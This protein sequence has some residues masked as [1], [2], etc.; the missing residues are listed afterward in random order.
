MDHTPNLGLPY[1]MAAQ[2]Q[3]HV[4]HNEAIRALDAILHLAV[5]DRDLTGPPASPADGDRYIVA[6]SATDAWSGH[7]HEIAAFQDGAW[8]FYPPREGW[9]AWLSDDNAAVVWDGTSWLPLA[10]GTG[11]GGPGPNPALL[12][13]NASADISNRLAVSSPASLFS[14]E[15]DGHQLKINKALASATASTLYQNGFSGRAEIGLTGDDDFHFKVSA[16]GDTWHEAIV[17]A[18]GTGAVTFP[19]TVSG[20]GGG[21]QLLTAPRTYHVDISAGSDTNTGL[22]SGAAF[23][24]IQKAIDTVAS[25]DTGIHDVTI[26]IAPGTYTAPNNLKPLSGAGRCYIVG[27]EA[28]PSSVIISLAS[29]TCF[30]ADSVYAIYHLRGMQLQT[31]A[32]GYGIKAA[33]HSKVYYRNMNFGA[34][35]NGHM[36][37]ENG[38]NI[39]AD[40]DYSISGNAPYHWLVS[41]GTIQAVGRTITLTGTPVFGSASTQSFASGL[42]TGAIVTIN[43]T[44]TGSAT[45]RRY[46]ASGNGLVDTNGAGAN[47]LPGST[48]GSTVTGGEYA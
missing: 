44:Y 37:A 28:L 27:D 6:A 46:F 9:I 23:A 5:H 34:C 12:G 11:G 25:L 19:N 48:S 30:N 31:A 24:T 2:A 10:T 22:T 40:G 20:G 41:V 1:I 43:N 47:A 16:D 3:K 35:T 8:M 14:H 13:I 45:G 36:Y 7:D 39:E 42:R 4:T 18:R 38:G 15:G 26:R 29:G 21:R 17:I 33:G 32:G